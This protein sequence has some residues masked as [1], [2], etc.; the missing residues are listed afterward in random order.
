[1][2]YS[3]NKILTNYR[4]Y[5]KTIFPTSLS[6]TLNGELFVKI[7]LNNFKNLVYFLKKHTQSQYKI[8]SDICALDYP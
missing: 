3:I 5:L 4:N 6:Y 2:K 8:L 7:P 1:M